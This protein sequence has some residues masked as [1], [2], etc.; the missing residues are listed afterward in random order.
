MWLRSACFTACPHRL[1]AEIIGVILGLPIRWLCIEVFTVGRNSTIVAIGER[2]ADRGVDGPGAS[3]SGS[4]RSGPPVSLVFR[5]CK[6]LCDPVPP[7]CRR[8]S[9]GR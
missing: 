5:S 3:A 8:C 2:K 1:S 7:R 4:A 6:E 9:P